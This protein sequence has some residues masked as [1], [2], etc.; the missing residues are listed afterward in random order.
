MAGADRRSKGKN[1]P[2]QQKCTRGFRRKNQ[3]GRELSPRLDL[4]GF[5][6]TKPRTLSFYRHDALQDGFG[7]TCQPKRQ[8]RRMAGVCLS[9]G[10]RRPESFDSTFSRA[11][12]GST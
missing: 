12:V 8:W 2:R 3:E 9:Y 4:G 5:K 11:A 7:E 1:H 10:K 6:R